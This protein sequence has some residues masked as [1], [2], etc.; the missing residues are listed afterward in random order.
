M[1]L[2]HS[3]SGARYPKNEEVRPSRGRTSSADSDRKSQN[4]AFTDNTIVPETRLVPAPT[5]G[6]E[7][8]PVQLE[9]DFGGAK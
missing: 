1:S 8:P 6:Q 3:N 2:Q 7:D 9:L 4:H 5:G